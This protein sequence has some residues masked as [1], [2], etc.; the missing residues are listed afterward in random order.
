M[1]NVLVYFHDVLAIAR[2]IK[3]NRFPEICNDRDV[4][5]Q[6]QWHYFGEEISDQLI[7]EGFFVE[8]P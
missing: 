1:M 5:W 2:L 7:G 8:R 4:C 3:G 6:V